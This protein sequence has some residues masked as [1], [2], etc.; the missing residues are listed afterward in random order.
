MPIVVR[1][2]VSHPTS[3]FLVISTNSKSDK[4]L[5]VSKRGLE[6][7]TLRLSGA[8]SYLLSYLP[9]IHVILLLIEVYPKVCFQRQQSNS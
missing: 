4:S 1:C 3:T 5:L 8:Y 6:P 2:N 9:P 7:L